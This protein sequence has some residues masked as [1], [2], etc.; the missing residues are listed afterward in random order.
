MPR[1]L[2]S[3]MT[4]LNSGKMQNKTI[5]FRF[6][7]YAFIT[8]ITLPRHSIA[9]SCLRPSKSAGNLHR[10]ETLECIFSVQLM[11]QLRLEV[12]GGRAEQK[13]GSGEGGGAR[14]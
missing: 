4:R 14:K 3:W 8:L 13:W 11:A 1:K 7:V 12:G 10:T 5:F 6:R 9:Q 2:F